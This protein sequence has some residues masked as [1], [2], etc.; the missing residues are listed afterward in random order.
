VKS[1][2]TQRWWSA[3]AL[4][5]AACALSAGDAQAHLVTTGLGPV[6]DGAAH[7]ALTPE[8]LLAVVALAVLGGLRGSAQA[9]WMLFALAPFWLLGGLAGVA[10]GL[11]S[12]D[13]FAA[14]S[15]LLVGVL[16]ATDIPLP[17]WAAGALAAVVGLVHGFADGS[18][19]PDEG[20]SLLMLVGISGAAFVIFAFVAA[21]LL[22]L[23]SALARIAMR[24]SASWIAA[25]GLLLLGWALRG[26]LHIAGR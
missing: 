11:P 6:Y 23:R 5:G 10:L 19:C 20:R 26:A 21:L 3:P 1:A 2:A 14:A 8:N 9:R 16:A 22:P 18:A 24:V 12:D 7:F 17:S 4:S 15:L 25:S 13:L